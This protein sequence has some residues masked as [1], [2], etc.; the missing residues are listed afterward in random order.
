MYNIGYWC[1]RTH[2]HV[3]HQ[4]FADDTQLYISLYAADCSGC[5]SQIEN[6]LQSLHTWFYTN[7]LALNPDKSDCILL[8][9]IQRA[10]SLES[11]SAV[12]IAGSIVPLSRHLKTLGVTF[13]CRL[14]FDQHVSSICKSSYFHIRALRHIRSSLT[15]DTANSIACSLVKRALTMLTQFCL[16]ISSWLG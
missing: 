1:L 14:S 4:Q 8:G 12:N 7:G 11:I 13:D 6:C 10:A 15:V 2:Q 9:T 3:S 5:L 16:N